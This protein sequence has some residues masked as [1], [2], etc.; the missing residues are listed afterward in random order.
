MNRYETLVS[1]CLVACGLTLLLSGSADAGV[2]YTIDWP[3]VRAAPPVN[4]NEGGDYACSIDRKAPDALGSRLLGIAEC[5]YPPTDVVATLAGTKGYEFGSDTTG[6][7]VWWER[8]KNERRIPYAATRAALEH[9]LKLTAKYRKRDYREPGARRMYTS[10]LVYLASIDKESEYELGDSSFTGV[11][12][13]R[14]HLMWSYDDGTFLP[15]VTA[16]RTVVLSPKGEILAV[17][18]DGSAVEDVSFSANQAVGGEKQLL[19]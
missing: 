8:G 16:R 13:A 11:Y 17:D 2:R 4:R 5:A 14:V 6:A 18:G 7:L 19:H 9:Y 12:V 1:C 10:N 15:T 3:A